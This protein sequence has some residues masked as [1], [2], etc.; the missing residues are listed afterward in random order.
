LF[1][2]IFLDGSGK[3]VGTNVMENEN[4]GHFGMMAF[5]WLKIFNK[6][7]QHNYS[8]QGFKVNLLEY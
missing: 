2:E 5:R 3:E 8:A 6:V 1:S 7:V 4:L